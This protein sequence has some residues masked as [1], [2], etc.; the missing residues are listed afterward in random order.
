MMLNL[1][2]RATLASNGGSKIIIPN[3]TTLFTPKLIVAFHQKKKYLEQD[4]AFTWLGRI[5]EA[6]ASREK[7]ILGF[8]AHV[9]GNHWVAVVVDVEYQTV[10]LGDPMGNRMDMELEQALN[11][12]TSLHFGTTFMIDNMRTPEQRDQNSCGVLA[13]IAL[14]NFILPEPARQQAEATDPET[15]FIE[16]KYGNTR[17]NAYDA[18][19]KVFL[20]IVARHEEHVRPL[21]L[22]LSSFLNVLS[23]FRS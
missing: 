20:D 23:V 13:W 11:W 12:W 21:F 16:M 17:I 3:E 15:K 10:W 7:E 14:R 1:L 5:G 9:G 4:P 19:L 18:R 6:L 22:L 2:R 8:I